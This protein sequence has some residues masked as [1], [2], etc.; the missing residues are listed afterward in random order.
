MCLKFAS[1]NSILFHVSGPHS[2]THISSV[3]IK[4]KKI[5]QLYISNYEKYYPLSLCQK[6]SRISRMPDLPQRSLY[7][8][9]QSQ[10]ALKNARECWIRD[11]WKTKSHRVAKSKQWRPCLEWNPL[12]SDNGSG[13]GGHRV[14]GREITLV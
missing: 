13:K 8:S 10:L 3:K 7:Q 5:I 6:K 9:T 11:S 4:S 14:K 12:R 1:L 2:F